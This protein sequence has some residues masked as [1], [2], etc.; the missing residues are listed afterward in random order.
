[1]P[2][3]QPACLVFTLSL[4]R[5]LPLPPGLPISLVA[6]LSGNLRQPLHAR[7]PMYTAPPIHRIPASLS[8]RPPPLPSAPSSQPSS[9]R[10]LQ[11]LQAARA[12][13]HSAAKGVPS[14]VIL[15]D[16]LKPLFSPPLLFSVTLLPSVP[17]PVSL[18]QPS[19]PSGTLGRDSLGV[20]P[21]WGKKAELCIP[22][23][24]LLPFIRE[25]KPARL[26]SLWPAT[27]SFPTPRATKL[28]TPGGCLHSKRRPPESGPSSLGTAVWELTFGVTLRRTSSPWFRQAL[29]AWRRHPR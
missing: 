5:S 18:P 1:M 12:V 21:R 6:S 29:M 2:P 20:I 4:P 7:S 24:L 27:L 28:A 23:S 9:S 26:G 13:L 17:R 8:P 22:P 3:P 25:N 10:S 15:V 19:L 16:T 11:K 14:K